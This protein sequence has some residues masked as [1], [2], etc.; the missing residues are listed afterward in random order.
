MGLGEA[1]RRW[2]FSVRQRVGCHLIL[3]LKLLFIFEGLRVLSKRDLFSVPFSKG[4][5][6]NIRILLFIGSW[7]LSFSST[8]TVCACDIV[9]SGTI[10]LFHFNGYVD[11]WLPLPSYGADR[12]LIIFKSDLCPYSEFPDWRYIDRLQWQLALLQINKTPSCICA[13]THKQ[14]PETV[15]PETRR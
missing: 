2:I 15:Q 13:A 6:R 11:A 10:G 9:I 8:R 14:T 12:C 1:Q 4:C 7:R 3:L 5:F